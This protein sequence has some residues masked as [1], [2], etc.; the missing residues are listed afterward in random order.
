MSNPLEHNFK[1]IKVVHPQ[2]L[3]DSGDTIFNDAGDANCKGAYS[4]T[5]DPTVGLSA[6][7]LDY[8]EERSIGLSRSSLQPF[9]EGYSV[10]VEKASIELVIMGFYISGF[11]SLMF[12]KLRTQILLFLHP[13]S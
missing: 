5:I 10:V 9:G 1:C 2:S 11:V 3:P 8:P 6:E 12:L 7:G 13:S 4:C